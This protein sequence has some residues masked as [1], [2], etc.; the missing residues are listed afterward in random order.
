LVADQNL[1]LLTRR[2]S[3]ASFFRPPIR[4]VSTNSVLLRPEAETEIDKG[5]DI[6][7]KEITLQIPFPAGGRIG[8]QSVADRIE[9]KSL[10]AACRSV[11]EKKGVIAE[12]FKIDLLRPDKRSD[13]RNLEKERLHD[14]PSPAETAS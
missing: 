14:S 2:E 10:A 8:V 12:G 6:V 13:S 5:F 3:P 1:R 11:N 9:E 4:E 7:G